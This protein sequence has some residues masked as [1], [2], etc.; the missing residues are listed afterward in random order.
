M[1]ADTM[2]GIKAKYLELYHQLRLILVNKLNTDTT[3]ET[4]A[5]YLALLG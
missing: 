4:E 3:G 5:L 1:G 2:S